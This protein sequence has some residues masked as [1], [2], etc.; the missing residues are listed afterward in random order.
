MWQDLQIPIFGLL[1]GDP[2]G[3]KIMLC[4]RFGAEKASWNPE[5]LSIP[6]LKW[7]G[8]HNSDTKKINESLLVK[9][10]KVLNPYS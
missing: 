6:Q 8:L 4:Y 3:I 2:G 10:T 5:A 9:L 7:I 1:D